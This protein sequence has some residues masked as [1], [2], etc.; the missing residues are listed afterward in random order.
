MSL[1]ILVGGIAFVSHA[2]ADDTVLLP[3]E[4]PASSSSRHQQGEGNSICLQKI[5]TEEINSSQ[6]LGQIHQLAA[7]VICVPDYCNLNKPGGGLSCVSD[8]RRVSVCTSQGKD[9]TGPRALDTY[10]T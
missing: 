3:Q 2:T 10:S 5:N 8:E 4:P 1:I 9:L 6:I 7:H